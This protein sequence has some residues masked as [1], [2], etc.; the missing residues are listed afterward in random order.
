MSC[1]RYTRAIPGSKAGARGTGGQPGQKPAGDTSYEKGTAPDEDEVD[2]QELRR[3]EEELRSL[4]DA[5]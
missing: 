2:P 4:G 1:S 5:D 3:R